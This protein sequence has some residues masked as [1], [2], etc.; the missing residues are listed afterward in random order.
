MITVVGYR[1]H[2]EVHEYIVSIWGGGGGGR[3]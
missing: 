3:T 1:A 2:I